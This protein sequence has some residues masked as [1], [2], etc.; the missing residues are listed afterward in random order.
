MKHHWKPQTK[1]NFNLLTLKSK[2]NT[3]YN[4][5]KLRAF[6]CDP[7]FVNN[8][9]LVQDWGQK[10]NN[11]ISIGKIREWDGMVRTRLI[12]VNFRRGSATPRFMKPYL[13]A[14]AEIIKENQKR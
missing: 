6:F 5:K 14:Q 13:N 12:Q 2:K 3:I 10:I 1:K 7:Y 9:L 8:F 11:D 4:I